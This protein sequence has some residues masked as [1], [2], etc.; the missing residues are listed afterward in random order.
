MKIVVSLA[1]YEVNMEGLALEAW[2]PQPSDLLGW[3]MGLAW[4]TIWTRVFKFE[5]LVIEPEN[6]YEWIQFIVIFEHFSPFFSSNQVNM[7]VTAVKSW[8]L[9]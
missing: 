7:E 4:E 1:F 5:N 3:R 9:Y 2:H 6:V 8:H